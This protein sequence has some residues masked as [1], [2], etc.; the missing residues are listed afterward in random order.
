M[1]EPVR[2]TFADSKRERMVGRALEKAFPHYILTKTPPFHPTDF[3][4]SRLNDDASMTYWGDLE[5]KWFKHNSTKR[6][7]FNFNKLQN[8]AILPPRNSKAAH[9]ICFRYD[10]GLL[11]VPVEQL[12][13]LFPFWFTRQDTDE[14]D[15][16]V[17]IDKDDL[18]RSHKAC[19]LDL[20]VKE[21]Y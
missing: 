18:L 15:L 7:V 14:T 17:V 9:R 8:L 12:M 16:V 6:A 21:G 19:W 4:V 5:I 11:I 10:D 1:G 20:I 3:H 13:D 2:Q